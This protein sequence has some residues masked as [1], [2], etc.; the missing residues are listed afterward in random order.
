[1]ARLTISSL[2]WIEGWTTNS[3]CTATNI[4]QSLPSPCMCNVPA[5]PS[6]LSHLLGDAVLYDS[7]AVEL[8]QAFSGQA[9]NQAYNGLLAA[10]WAKSA[11]LLLIIDH[12]L[13]PADRGNH[14]G[15]CVASW[16]TD[17]MLVGDISNWLE[18]A[19]YD[20]GVAHSLNDQVLPPQQAIR[21]VGP[22]K[23]FFSFGGLEDVERNDSFRHQSADSKHRE[24]RIQHCFRLT[25]AFTSTRLLLSGFKLSLWGTV[26][27]GHEEGSF[28]SSTG[29][30]SDK[31]E[32]K[33]HRK[34][35]LSVS[36]MWLKAGRQHNYQL[37]EVQKGWIYYSLDLIGGS[38][39]SKKM[40][41]NQRLAYEKSTDVHLVQVVRLASQEE[42][43]QFFLFPTHFAWLWISF[44]V[45]LPYRYPRSLRL[46]CSHLWFFHLQL[47][48]VL[49]FPP[50][51][52][53]AMARF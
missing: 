50:F 39:N 48:V 45:W 53:S 51:V 42:T 30:C 6:F 25:L 33:K 40:S 13:Q 4:K 38:E 17:N 9:V 32:R 37:I 20:F 7:G 5:F 1:M 10:L 21:L 46:P 16:K 24:R 52:S 26:L 47:W 11:L 3:T 15:S 12:L 43:L 28:S 19:L 23:V 29:S 8:Q 34:W 36:E 44:Q 18:E 31:R 14:A 35:G 2:G 49:S 22:L 41:K 27:V